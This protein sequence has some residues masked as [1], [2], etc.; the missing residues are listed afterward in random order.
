[1]RLSCM[2]RLDP[3]LCR[4]VPHS[5]RE[6]TGKGASQSGGCAGTVQP[7]RGVL[8][9]CCLQMVAWSRPALEH[10]RTGS[11]RRSRE[12]GPGVSRRSQDRGGISAVTRLYSTQL[13]HWRTRHTLACSA[14]SVSAGRALLCKFGASL[15]VQARTSGG[16]SW[17]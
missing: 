10:L 5:K 12:R 7:P 2:I 16:K 4:V 1:M 17:C 13:E 3:C 6:W 11:I 9:L 15:A 8:R 14:R